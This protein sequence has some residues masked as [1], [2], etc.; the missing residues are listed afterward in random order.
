[1]TWRSEFSHALGDTKFNCANVVVTSLTLLSGEHLRWS[2]D[3]LFE[4][5]A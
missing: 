1:M 4:L 3:I 2:L 5:S